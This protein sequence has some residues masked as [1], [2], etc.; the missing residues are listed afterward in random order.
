MP[1][2]VFQARG[3]TPTYVDMRK[4]QISY[5]QKGGKVVVQCK[6]L[7][8]LEKMLDSLEAYY[9]KSPTLVKEKK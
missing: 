2:Y 1:T 7:T 6:S 9:H 5:F 4:R 3:K 8:Q